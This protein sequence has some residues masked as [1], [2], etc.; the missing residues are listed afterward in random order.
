VD[1]RLSR[2]TRFIDIEPTRIYR[3][4]DAREFLTAGGIDPERAARFIDGKFTSAVVRALKPGTRG[5]VV[6][7]SCRS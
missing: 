4:E 3:S 2:R 5:D 7:R 1:H 6:G